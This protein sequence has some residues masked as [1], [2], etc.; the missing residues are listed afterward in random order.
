MGGTHHKDAAVAPGLPV[1]AQEIEEEISQAKRFLLARLAKEAEE[2]RVSLDGLVSTRDIASLMGVDP[3]QVWRAARR[4]RIKPA[5]TRG[6][7]GAQYY[8][9]EDAKVIVRLVS[10]AVPR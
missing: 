9:E 3:V 1:T 7:G 2:T 10:A 4:G 8:N 6:K 5:A